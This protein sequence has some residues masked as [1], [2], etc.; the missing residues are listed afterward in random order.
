MRKEKEIERIIEENNI[1]L[2]MEFVIRTMRV[3]EIAN[4]HMEQDTEQSDLTSSYGNTL[5]HE[6]NNYISGE[7]LEMAL[8]KEIVGEL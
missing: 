7:E 4:S 8:E 5:F 1:V 3:L 2:P 6:I